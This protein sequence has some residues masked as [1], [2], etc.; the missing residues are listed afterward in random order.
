GEFQISVAFWD[1]ECGEIDSCN[2]YYDVYGG[3]NRQ[4][5][6]YGASVGATNDGMI[7]ATGAAA[8]AAAF[9]PYLNMAEGGHGNYATGQSYVV[10]PHHL[11]QY[12]TMNSSRGYAQQYGTPI[13][14]T[15]TPTMQPADEFV[16]KDVTLITSQLPPPHCKF[17]TFNL[18][19][20]LE[21]R[22][23]RRFIGR[24]CQH[25][26]HCPISEKNLKICWRLSKAGTAF[27]LGH[28]HV[29]A[30]QMLSENISD[31]INR[32][33]RQRKSLMGR[34][35]DTLNKAISAKSYVEM[36]PTH[37]REENV[38]KLA[39]LMQQLLSLEV[40][41]KYFEREVAAKALT[42]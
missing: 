9:Y 10:Y 16:R 12:S 40:A 20:I 27:I 3:R 23:I 22:I 32:Y 19:V 41:T 4:Y 31:D 24:F 2:I 25:R 28:S 1:D 34:Q 37:I 8:A 30:K 11:Y 18:C 35:R 21:I 17:E 36:V 14:L 38:A 7:T 42:S 15:A 13:S 6:Y 33:R 39:T 29:K 5:T 26:R